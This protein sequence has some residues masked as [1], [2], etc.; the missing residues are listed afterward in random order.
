M[1]VRS[2]LT[3]LRAWRYCAHGG[4]FGLELL[5]RDLAVVLEILGKVDG[6]HATLAEM[7]LDAVAAG[8]GRG[9]RSV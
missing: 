3:I 1:C 4:E 7:S 8:K 6:R 2:T 9:M 5:E